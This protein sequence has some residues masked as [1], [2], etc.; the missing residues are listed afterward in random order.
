MKISKTTYATVGSKVAE[1]V[2]VY[3]VQVDAENSSMDEFTKYIAREAIRL[4]DNGSVDD[5]IFIGITMWIA[6]YLGCNL[7]DII[8]KDDGIILNIYVDDKSF[9][10]GQLSIFSILAERRF[11]T[12]VEEDRIIFW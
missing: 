2:F 10:E 3:S 4:C 6:D 12:T 11:N 1:A 9:M 7:S 5:Y 8:K